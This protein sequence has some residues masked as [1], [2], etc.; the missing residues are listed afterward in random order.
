MSNQLLNNWSRDTNTSFYNQRYGFIE[1]PNK[2]RPKCAVL[3]SIKSIYSIKWAALFKYNLKPTLWDDPPNRVPWCVSL[4]TPRNG[5]DIDFIVSRGGLL[6]FTYMSMQVMGLLDELWM[7]E[8]H[9]WVK[10][11][12]AS[13]KARA[14]GRAAQNLGYIGHPA[15]GN[16][17]ARSPSVYRAFSWY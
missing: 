13:R 10:W 15:Y 7:K 3:T 9:I 11:C 16:W 8:T 1:C 6:C 4:I 12:V 17:A 14:G 2:C 5:R